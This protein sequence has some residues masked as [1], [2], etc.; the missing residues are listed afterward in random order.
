MQVNIQSK[1]AEFAPADSFDEP[2]A[3]CSDTHQAE[4]IA[5]AEYSDSEPECTVQ[6]PCCASRSDE[7]DGDMLTVALGGLCAA[8]L[9]M[10]LLSK[11]KVR[12]E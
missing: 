3:E 5:A 12:P 4:E 2:V 10:W 6:T 8:L 1:I 11:S 9:T 7:D